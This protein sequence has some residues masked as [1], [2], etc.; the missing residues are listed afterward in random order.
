MAHQLKVDSLLWPAGG[1]SSLVLQTSLGKLPSFPLLY[2][3]SDI[4]PDDIIG[5]IACFTFY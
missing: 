1:R 3:L 4:I 2:Q 5:L